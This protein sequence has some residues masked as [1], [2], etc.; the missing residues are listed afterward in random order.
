MAIFGLLLIREVPGLIEFS[1]EVIIG[2]HLP[3]VAMAAVWLL[4]PILAL[5]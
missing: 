4:E 3:P 5:S 1:L 2:S